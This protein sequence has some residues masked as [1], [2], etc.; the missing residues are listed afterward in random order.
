MIFRLILI[1]A[2]IFCCAS[3]KAQQNTFSKTYA[4]IG[5]PHFHTGIGQFAE[6]SIETNDGYIFLTGGSTLSVVGG[7]GIG[8]IKTDKN[9]NELWRQEKFSNEFRYSVSGKL[10]MDG[11]SNI[12]A[13]YLRDTSITIESGS[14]GRVG[15]LMLDKYSKDG[16][17]IWS[18]P[19]Y[20]E[21]APYVVRC[22]GISINNDKIYLSGIWIDLSQTTTISIGHLSTVLFCIN[23]NSGELQ[24]IKSYDTGSKDDYNDDLL[25]SDDGFIY[26]SGLTN[27]LGAS[28][29]RGHLIK[30]DMEGNMIWQ[31]LFNDI[32]GVMTINSIDNSNFILTGINP[33]Q[34]N[35]KGSII[36]IDSSGERINTNN[37]SF[38]E[39][40]DF[41]RSSQISDNNLVTVG[42]SNMSSN[43]NNCGLIQKSTPN[44]E[45]LWRHRYDYGP[46]SDFFINFIETTDNHLL[47]IGKAFT[48]FETGAD[49]WLLK[50]DSNG[51]LVPGCLEVGI[52]DAEQE[53]GIAIYPNP[54]QDRLFIK[55]EQNQKKPLSFSLYN[56]QGKLIIQEQLVAEYESFDLSSLQSGVYLVNIVDGDGKKVSR[57]IIKN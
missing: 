15:I 51:C 1:L 4:L 22:N 42:L 21:I 40:L 39:S 17:L 23:K 52:N 8:L 48:G 7:S 5:P 30:T 57:K 6:G 43:T 25:I 54:T 29:L 38:I 45:L 34:P 46:N 9:G 26:L 53:M 16:T 31:K 13:Y 41:Y 55:M 47:V 20:N 2:L 27:G 3:V 50:L 33:S 35:T 11:D 19:Y 14:S 36:E 12:Y 28:G 56:L 18:I 44:G 37:F 24:W 32:A 10:I 49:A